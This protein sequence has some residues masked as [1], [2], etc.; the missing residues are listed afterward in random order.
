MEI[1][2]AASLPGIALSGEL[3]YADDTD[4]FYRFKSGAWQVIPNLTEIQGMMPKTFIN[5]T[6]KTNQRLRWADSAVVTGG[7]GNAT[8]YVT[9]DLTSSGTA[10]ATAIDLDTVM[11]RTEDNTQQYTFGTVTSPNVKTVIVN[12]FRQVFSGI[13]VLSLNVLGSVASNAAPNGTVVKM[14]LDGDAA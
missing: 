13:V 3:A 11:V 1:D 2:I 6:Q 8:F 7:A 4:R 12:V 5:G 14:T 10:R 9:S